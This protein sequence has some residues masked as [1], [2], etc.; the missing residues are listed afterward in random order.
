MQYISLS[1]Q[2]LHRLSWFCRQLHRFSSIL[3]SRHQHVYTRNHRKVSRLQAVYILNA[4][5]PFS[6]SQHIYILQYIS[7][8]S[9]AK[10]QQRRALFLVCSTQQKTWV[11]CEMSGYM[12]AI[13]KWSQNSS[14]FISGLIFLPYQRWCN[15]KSCSG[16]FSS[17][18]KCQVGCV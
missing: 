12:G 16:F 8:S 18:Y 11:Q 3:G 14:C 1:I 4:Y 15:P 9:S 13:M 7:L 2:N 17:T 6:I 5:I 10:C